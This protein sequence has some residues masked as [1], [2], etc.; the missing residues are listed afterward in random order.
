[1]PVTFT[2]PSATGGQAPV[3][4]SCTAASGAAFPVGSTVVTCTATDALSRQASCSFAVTVTVTPR[5]AKTKFLAFGDS[6]T[7]GRCGIAPTTCPPYT[8]RL[9]EL[10]MSRYTAQTFTIRTEGKPGQTA[11]GDLARLEGL[12]DK[13]RPDVL[14]LMEGSNDVN[15]PASGARRAG[16]DGLEDMLRAALA[17]GITVFVATI[18]PER[19]GGVYDAS[20]FL[21]PGF[22]DGVRAMVAA[23]GGYLV[24]VY[25]AINADLP[26]Y[27][28]ADDLHPTAE[29]L[30]RIGETFYAAIRGAL[31][32]TPGG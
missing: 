9:K 1:V 22:N 32:M 6:I 19:A 13:D 11:A 31:D 10:L 18:P 30:Q 25:A 20:S 26:R 4:V 29:G 14:L 24:D 12:L 23:K 3:T 27:I 5:I 16:L 21:I 2:V 15:S 7:F 8:V 28:G 17:R